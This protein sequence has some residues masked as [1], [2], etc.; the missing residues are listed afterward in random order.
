M[1]Y[2]HKHSI[3]LHNKRQPPLNL[4]ILNRLIIPRI[5][6]IPRPTSTIILRRVPRQGRKTARRDIASILE[7]IRMTELAT[8]RINRLHRTFRRAPIPIRIIP[9]IT[10]LPLL[11]YSIPTHGLFHAITLVAIQLTHPRDIPSRRKLIVNRGDALAVQADERLASPVC[12]GVFAVVHDGVDVV[13]AGGVLAED[14]G[15]G[16]GPAPAEVVGAAFGGVA[17]A[18]GGGAAVGGVVGE[19]GA[20]EED[21]VVA[22]G[23]LVLVEEA[24]GV[25]KF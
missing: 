4:P 25:A 13:G 21:V 24:E 22:V 1:T 6:L 11:Q 7:R 23:A 10:L 19:G 16:A 18:G 9:I 17:G 8:P 14:V 2:F 12:E 15:E 20:V 3:L 5:R